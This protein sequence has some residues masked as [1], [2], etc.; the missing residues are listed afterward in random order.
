MSG[1]T[2]LVQVLSG[3]SLAAI[4]FIVSSGMTLVFGTMRVINMTHG[5][6]YM[7]G[8]YLLA[9]TFD[10]FDQHLVGFVGAFLLSALV[11]LVLG[12]IIEFVVLRRLYKGEHLLQLLATWALM[13]IFE[14]LALDVWGSATVTP[15]S[16]ASLSGTMTLGAASIP[17]FY[18]F[19]ILFAALI[20]VALWIFN[21]RMGIGRLL[22]AAVEDHELLS[23]IGVNVRR[24]YTVAFA[25]GAFL[26]ALGGALIA[27]EISVGPGIDLSILVESF[28]VAVVGGLGNINGAVIG[29]II[30][31]LAQSF[32]ATYI[33]NMAEASI[34]FVMVVVLIVRPRGLF[35]REEF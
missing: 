31:G 12:I 16:P 5:S 3:L 29:A 8:A 28:V 22:R 27:P 2:L 30:I 17:V 4:L 35:G 7:F 14:Q 11:V 20:F 34:Y 9:I 26:A 21:N 25:V 33:P 18:V 19:L 24:L 13:L 15:P 1:G 23:T 32:G 6:F 10:K